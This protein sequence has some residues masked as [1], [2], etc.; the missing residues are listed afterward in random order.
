MG[1]MV[2][3]FQ[4]LGVTDISP[5]PDVSTQDTRGTREFTPRPGFE[6][7]MPD[8]QKQAMRYR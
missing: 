2:D 4:E 1:Y 7:I 5:N 6:S 3:K 8:E